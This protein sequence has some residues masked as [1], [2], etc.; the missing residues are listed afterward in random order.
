MDLLWTAATPAT[1]PG[2]KL[3]Y[4]PVPESFREVEQ[5]EPTITTTAQTVPQG[6]M[7]EVAVGEPVEEQTLGPEHISEAVTQTT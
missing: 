7:E 4:P 2:L 3:N 1:P 5:K 6:A